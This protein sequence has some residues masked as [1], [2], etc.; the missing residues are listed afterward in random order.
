ML[1]QTGGRKSPS[2]NYSSTASPLSLSTSLSPCKPNLKEEP[3]K[4]TVC[5]V[6]TS[7]E[8]A[9]PPKQPGAATSPSTPTTASS[10]PNVEADWNDALRHLT[11]AQDNYERQTARAVALADNDRAR[12]S[13]LATNFPAQPLYLLETGKVQNEVEL[14][15][16]G[17]L[18]IIGPPDGTCLVEASVRAEHCPQTGSS[19]VG[20]SASMH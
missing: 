15:I 8:P 12:T 20:V 3:P 19:G 18:G 17:C 2:A 5:A 13:A 6:N 10:P 4:P 11:A 16:S 9:T 7:N 1:A 14:P